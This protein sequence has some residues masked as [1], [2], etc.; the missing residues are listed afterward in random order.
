[1]TSRTAIAVFASALLRQPGAARALNN[2]N[3]DNPTRSRVDG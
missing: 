3:L 1:M 2:A